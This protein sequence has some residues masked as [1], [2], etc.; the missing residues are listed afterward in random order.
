M[1]TLTTY[2]AYPGT[3]EVTT[4]NYDSA[5]GFMVSKVYPDN[6]QVTYTNDADGR[7]LTRVWARGITTTYAYDNGGSL[8]GV[9][10][11]G[12]TTPAISY[13]LDRMGRVTAVTDASGSRTLS[14]NADGTLAN[15]SI[16]YIVNGAVEYTYDDLGRRAGLQLTQNSSSVFTNSYT[17]DDMSRLATVSDDTN[18]VTYSRVPG[19]N[20]LN[21]TT[22][23]AGGVT[24]LNAT[25]NYDA[26]NRL[27]GISSVAGA[28]TK[29]YSY[30]YDDKDKRSRLDMTDGSHWLYTYDA[31]G[32][33]VSGAKYDSTNK[34][35][36]GQ[37]FNY[38]YDD[39]GNLTSE[40]RGMAAMQFDYTSNLV[41]QYTQRTIPGFIPVTGQASASSTVSVWL[42][43]HG[44]NAA[45]VVKPTRDGE[46]FSTTIP[47]NN[48]NANVTEALEITAVKFN[49]TL[50]KDVVKT[51]NGSYTVPKTPQ[52]FTYDDDGNTLSDGV[53]N[54]TW[55][56]DNRLI[57]AEKANNTKVEFKYDYIGRKIEKKVYS[58][59]SSAWSLVKTKRFVYDGWNLIA[60]YDDSGTTLRKSFLWGEDISNSLQG[61]GGVGGLLAETS[62]STS[63][64]PCYDG[65]GNVRAYVDNT[66]TIVAE[67]EYD[68]F[69]NV[70]TKN[71][72]K[73]DDF[74][75]RFSTKYHDKETGLDD[76]DNRLYSSE[77]RRWI[78]PDPAEEAGGNNLYGFVGNNPVS[79]CD[80]LGYALYAFDGTGNNE[81]KLSGYTNVWYLSKSYRGKAFYGRGVGTG[82]AFDQKNG[83]ITGEGGQERLEQM[84]DFL[85]KTYQ[86]G[87]NT[88]DIIGFSR[89]A[90]LA[91]AFANMIK[92]KGISKGTDHLAM[93]PGGNYRESD[94]N[95]DCVKIRFLGIFD[96]VA[97]FGIPGNNINIGYD[98][99]I[100]DIVEHTAHATARGEMRSMFPLSSI[101]AIDEKMDSRRKIEKSFPGAHSDVGGGYRNHPEA[102]YVPLKW[103]WQQ[104]NAAAG[105]SG[106]EPNPMFAPLPDFVGKY[107]N[108]P[109]ARNPYTHDSRLDEDGSYQN[110][111]ISDIDKKPGERNIFWMKGK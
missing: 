98:L 61:A 27:T 73:S 88:I 50:D 100:P 105:Q 79:Y 29:T 17:Y 18:T 74:L 44:A 31:K 25:R 13:T 87:D 71:G 22:I 30:T 97:S 63:Y 103:M 76:F 78:N 33:I 66:G 75:F 35:I 19:T 58:W 62:N 102:Q 8:T 12:S 2:K 60:V 9:S 48:N 51:I 15:E 99:S 109:L 37:A 36:P 95:F 86:G 11:S 45:A 28:V 10:Y 69:G 16:P 59:I 94:G 111:Y 89:G 39:I 107:L 38:S 56:G 80:Y 81:D 24:K 32:Q 47:V 96:T 46:Y 68:M 34:A 1:K 5:R 4:W 83:G 20:L 7:P 91:R 23:T 104:G 110:I 26:Q 54:Y 84:Y 43:N 65:S 101:Y 67:Y 40:Q 3:P 21:T 70:L 77:F 85:V 93:G 6:K 92:N 64:Y 14:Y 55:N 90:A 57:T 52:L 72:T 49:T 108:S 41:N 42:K 53:W 82:G 106:K